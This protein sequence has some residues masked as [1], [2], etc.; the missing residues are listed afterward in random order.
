MSDSVEGHEVMFTGGVHLDV[1]HEHHLV[2][3][4]IE[5]RRQHIFGTHA[6]PT[7]ELVVSARH[8]CGG[9]AQSFTVRILA[10]RNEQLTYR[11]LGT[12]KIHGTSRFHVNMNRIDR[13]H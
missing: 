3:T 13:T 10:D 12:W 9:I 6:K 5:G 11:C 2:V 8:A 1:A 4:N 7:E